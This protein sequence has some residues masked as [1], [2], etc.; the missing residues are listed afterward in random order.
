[1]TN[2]LYSAFAAHREM[3]TED[4]AREV[5]RTRPLSEVNPEMIGAIRAWGALHGRPV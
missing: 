3:T 1:V 4:I 5:A 2:A